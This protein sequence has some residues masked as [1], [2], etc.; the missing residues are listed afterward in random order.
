MLDYRSVPASKWPFEFTKWRSLSPAKVTYGSKQRHF[1]ETG[2]QQTLKQGKLK[3]SMQG[4]FLGQ[5][6]QKI[7]KQFRTPKGLVHFD[8]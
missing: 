7:K 6:Q 5:L 8:P 2:K 1:E 3:I 4:F